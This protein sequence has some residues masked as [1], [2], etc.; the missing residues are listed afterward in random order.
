MHQLVVSRKS[1]DPKVIFLSPGTWYGHKQYAATSPPPSPPPSPPL[2][3]RLLS[4]PPLQ[5]QYVLY[6]WQWERRHLIP[7]LATFSLEHSKEMIVVVNCFILPSTDLTHAPPPSPPPFKKKNPDPKH[8][9]L[10]K[11]MAPPCIFACV[12]A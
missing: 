7:S 10:T 12:H 6:Y 8:L 11:G 1:D 2:Q 3:P 4:L 9:C 5:L